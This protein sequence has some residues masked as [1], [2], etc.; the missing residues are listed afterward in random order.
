MSDDF[1]WTRVVLIRHGESQVTVNR[2]LGGPR[3]LISQNP[4]L[5][6]LSSTV[7][8]TPSP[9]ACPRPNPVML[10]IME[11]RRCWC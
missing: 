8:V 6:D 7:A 9:S 11:R 2:V 5:T 1:V 10:E 3:T 4:L